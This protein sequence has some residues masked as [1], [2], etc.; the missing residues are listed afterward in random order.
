MSIVRAAAQRV[1]MTPFITPTYGSLVPKSVSSAISGWAMV[2]YHLAGEP[3]LKERFKREAKV[4][5]RLNHP[6]IVQVYDFGTVERNGLSIYYM[7]MAYMPGPSLRD[8]MDQKRSCGEQFSLTEI[9]NIMRGV[10]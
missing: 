5:A 7:V 3:A 4:V 9:D 2:L 1:A 6:N 10:C 8:I